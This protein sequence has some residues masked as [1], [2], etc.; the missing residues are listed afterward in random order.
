MKTLYNN[1]FL[2]LLLIVGFAG[3]YSCKCAQCLT[4]PPPQNSYATMLVNTNHS[5][6]SAFAEG[7]IQR[8]VANKD[9]IC[10]NTV[11]AF[12]NVLN[13]SETFNKEWL[14]KLLCLKGSIGIRVHYG[15]DSIFKVHQI[16]TG[17]DQLGNDLYLT[18][19]P[20]DPIPLGGAGTLGERVAVE[21]GMPDTTG[22]HPPK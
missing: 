1:R 5:I 6:D 7:W 11:G 8:Y 3:L 17:V 12:N 14:Q 2:L 16:L 15:M 13:F 20:G 18:Y 10:N 9:S 19:E 21:A 22:T 4:T